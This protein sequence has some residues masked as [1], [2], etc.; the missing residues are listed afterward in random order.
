VPLRVAVI[1]IDETLTRCCREVLAELLCGSEWTLSVEPTPSSVSHYDLAIWDFSSSE[2]EVAAGL[3]GSL[4]RCFFVVQRQDV[5]ALQELSGTGDLHILLKPVSRATLLAFLSETLR[6]WQE[7][8]AQPTAEGTLRSERDEIL[9]CLMQANLK[10]QEYD[11]AR[12]NFL[13][14]SLHDFRAPLT[15]LA[16]YCDL[17]LEEQTGAVT[18]SQREILETMRCSTGRLS[19]LTDAMYQLS[20]GQRVDQRLRLTKGDI[21]ECIDQ[22]LLELGRVLDDK[23]L[24]VTVEVDPSPEPLLFDS[25]RLEQMLINL[26]DNACK[27]TPRGGSIAI[28]A[29]PF[30][31]DRRIKQLSA[32]NPAGERRVIQMM[33]PNSFRV[34][35]RDSGPGIST[36]HLSTIFEE[37]TSYAG[38]QDRS[39][40]GLGLAICKMIAQQHEGYVWA[41]NTGSGARFSVVLPFRQSQAPGTPEPFARLFDTER[42]SMRNRGCL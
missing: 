13:A 23:Q 1:S 31:W 42:M 28:R 20:I 11:Q 39:G 37:Y 30:F 41:E 36:H 17:L 27:F 38:G 40:G 4:K 35:I 26:L 16:G 24:Y 19:R 22:T 32:L 25:S 7:Q 9:Q 12:T 14:R 8:E 5:R 3:N 29:Y 18:Q 33:A 15:T 2:M 34:D 21:R 6:I 10:L